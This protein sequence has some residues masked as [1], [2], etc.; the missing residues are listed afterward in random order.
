[1]KDLKGA[2]N[3]NYSHGMCISGEYNSWAAM[4][5]RCLN[6]HSRNFSNYGGRGISICE[7]WLEF[8]NFFDDMGRKPSPRHTIDRKNNDGNYEPDNCKWATNSEQQSNKRNNRLLSCG[9]RT[10]TRTQW[11]RELEM[12]TS[13]MDYR[14]ARGWS[15]E[16]IIKTPVLRAV[17][18]T[19]IAEARKS[20][21][22]N[23]A[24]SS[25]CVPV[26]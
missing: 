25:G 6:P 22:N 12:N 15:D 5:S 19:R 16:K 26:A 23:C 21:L 10:Q 7:R 3:P 18:R 8:E 13:T 17:V 14:I 4:K 9:G 24:P 20:A 11:E 1:M 2:N